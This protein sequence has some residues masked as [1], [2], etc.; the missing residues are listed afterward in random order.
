MLDT[1][2]QYSFLRK[3][4][5]SILF[6]L[7][8]DFSHGTQLSIVTVQLGLVDLRY[9]RWYSGVLLGN[10]AQVSSCHDCFELWVLV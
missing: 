1:Y 2:T 8:I 4:D 6:S 3:H 10:T 9:M 5:I 7:S